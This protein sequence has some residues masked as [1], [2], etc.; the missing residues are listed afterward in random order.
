MNFKGESHRHFIH[1]LSE[2]EWEILITQTRASI[3]SRHKQKI[4]RPTKQADKDNNRNLIYI[5]C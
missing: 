3:D 5:E 1:I 4:G 2:N